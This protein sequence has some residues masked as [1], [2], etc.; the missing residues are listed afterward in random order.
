[1]CL[2]DFQVGFRYGALSFNI[3]SIEIQAFFNHILLTYA[4]T[5]PKKIPFQMRIMVAVL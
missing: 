4:L 3:L 1:M 5:P 2:Q